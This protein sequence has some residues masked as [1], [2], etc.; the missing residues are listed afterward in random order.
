MQIS[1][2]TII[3][4]VKGQATIAQ[5]VTDLKEQLNKTLPV[6]VKEDEHLATRINAVERKIWYFGGAG[7]V[8]GAL[9]SHFGGSTIRLF[10]GK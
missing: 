7:S 8:L 9:L 4:L 3:D 1:E 10:G 2:D 6:L 5:A